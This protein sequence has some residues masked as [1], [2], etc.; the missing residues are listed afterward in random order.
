MVIDQGIFIHDTKNVTSRYVVPHLLIA[1]H[2][3]SAISG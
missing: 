1:S 3:D 2:M